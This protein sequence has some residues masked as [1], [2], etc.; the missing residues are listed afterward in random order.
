MA[1]MSLKR[2][3]WLTAQFNKCE[4]LLPIIIRVTQWD[5][6]SVKNPNV[7]MEIKASTSPVG[8]IRARAT[9]STRVCCK[10]TRT[11]KETSTQDKVLE[12]ALKIFSKCRVCR[13]SIVVFNSLRSFRITRIWFVL[14]TN[15]WTKKTLRWGLPAVTCL[16]GTTLL[17]MMLN[18]CWWTKRQVFYM[19]PHW[20][21]TLLLK[22]PRFRWITL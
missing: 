11:T 6:I 17:N 2:K 22:T 1:Q 7:S 10:I 3:K 19:L 8:E 13:N 14:Q 12:G 18:S 20:M 16:K 9:A 15:I 5:K 21:E 4:T